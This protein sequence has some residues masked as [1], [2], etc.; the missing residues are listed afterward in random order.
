M[1][2]AASVVTVRDD[3]LYKYAGCGLQNV[4]LANGYETHT[5]PTGTLA[6]TIKSFDSLHACIVEQLLF[7]DC[8]LGIDE[9]T[10][11]RKESGDVTDDELWQLIVNR[12]RPWKSKIIPNDEIDICKGYFKKLTDP[13][14]IDKEQARYI[15]E[16]SYECKLWYYHSAYTGSKREVDIFR[17]SPAE[18]PAVQYVFVYRDS[19]WD[20]SSTFIENNG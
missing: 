10:F 18:R 15:R 19:K 17:C 5:T 20:L 13:Q 3:Y 12:A 1:C 16:I 6:T 2:D 11:L 7:S 8:V 14:D 4:W 9:I